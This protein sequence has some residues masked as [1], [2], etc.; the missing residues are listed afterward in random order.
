MS[1]KILIARLDRIGDVVLSTPVIKA[2]R[3]AYPDSYIAMMV[4]P[5]A[6]EIVEGNPYLNEVIIYDKEGSHKGAWGNL[7]FIQELKDR[8]F[9]IAVILHP[10]VRT[11]MVLSLALI[12]ERIG[13]DK[14]AGFM[15]TKKIPHTK[16][17]GLKHEADYALDMLRCI[18]IEPRDRKLCIPVHEESERK[19]KAVFASNGIRESDT[20]IAVHP[21]ASCPSKRWSAERFARVA[22]RLTEGY[23]AK[24][25]IIASEKDR[26]FGDKV[27]SL[28]KGPS[29]N[30]SGKTSVADLASVLKRA[31]LFISNDSGPVHIACAVGTPVVD[32]FGRN[33]RGL[34]PRRWGPTGANDVVIHKEVGCEVC[35]AH[36]CK[37]GFKCLDAITVDEVVEAG[38]RILRVPGTGYRGPGSK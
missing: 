25:V 1:K 19:V 4:R 6:R 20:V 16:Q 28:M 14:K 5:H 34:S 36:N 21:G 13:Y 7:K 30:L 3:D 15:L 26:A 38:E 24:V 8:K 31:K 17:F 10:T 9:D 11:H 2:L 27:A 35:L 32:I 37:L 22:D 33:D 23:N 18:G 29:L 12:P